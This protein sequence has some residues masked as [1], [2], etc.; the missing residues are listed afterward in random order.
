[1]TQQEQQQQ[2]KSKTSLL[3]FVG[4]SETQFVSGKYWKNANPNDEKIAV[5]HNNFIKGAEEK[6]RRFREKGLW[7]ELADIEITSTAVVFSEEWQQEH[8]PVRVSYVTSFGAEPIEGG[9]RNP[10]GREM[11]AA[12]LVNIHNPHLDQIVVFLHGVATAE[13]NC[14]DFLSDMRELDAKI[15]LSALEKTDPFFKVCCVNIPGDQP[16]YFQMFDFTLHEAV[17]GDIVVLSN[18]DQVFD[19]SMSMARYLNPN[20]LVVLA[21]HGFSLGKIPP[22]IQHFYV[23]IVGEEYLHLQDGTPTT[24]SVDNMC[25]SNPY[26]WDTW[27]FDKN[28]LRDRLKEEHFRRPLSNKKMATFTMNE[29]GAENAAMWALQQTFP[30]SSVYNACDK[31]RS[32]TF[33]LTHKTHKVHKNPWQCVRRSHPCGSVP[34]PWGGI[35]RKGSLRRSH[36]LVPK[37]PE[38]VHANSCF[39]MEPVGV[40]VEDV[41]T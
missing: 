5:L 35:K 14:D 26:S 11:E 12:L 34:Y 3:K 27:I 32:W 17:L 41:V 22:I 24:N 31:I 13:T 36:P 9:A 39:L 23:T 1:L 21:T 28:V 7:V 18:A 40:S 20:V 29:L 15:G 33:H 8:P 6:R 38:C 19:D 30:F 16:N 4:L 10:H 2:L 37:D 25:V